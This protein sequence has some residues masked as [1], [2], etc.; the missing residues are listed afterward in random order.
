MSS[1]QDWSQDVVSAQN[2]LC[3]LGIDVV[4]LLLS[5]YGYADADAVALERDPIDLPGVMRGSFYKLH[6]TLAAFP[7]LPRSQASF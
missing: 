3:L 2:D 1:V 4:E 5:R 6:H 7:A